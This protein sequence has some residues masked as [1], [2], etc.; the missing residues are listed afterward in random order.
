[1][2]SPAPDTFFPNDVQHKEREPSTMFSIHQHSSGEKQRA[3]QDEACGQ[4]PH[5]DRLRSGDGNERW[6]GCSRCQEQQQSTR[7]EHRCGAEEAQRRNSIRHRPLT[8]FNMVHCQRPSQPAT[9]NAPL[10]GRREWRTRY[11]RDAASTHA[12]DTALFIRP[13]LATHRGQRTVPARWQ[14]HADA[15]RM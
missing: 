2:T 9:P 8:L 15:D 10:T 1:M 6:N 7:P 12:K 3:K 13:Q 11:R 14:R 4:E 5:H